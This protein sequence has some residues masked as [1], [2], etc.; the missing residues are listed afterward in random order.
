MRRTGVVALVGGLLLA[1]PAAGADDPKEGLKLL[2]KKT[3]TD[4]AGK[5]LLYRLLKPENYDAKE[6]YPLVVF[7]HGAGER[8]NDNE[9]QLKHGVKEF[10][11]AD[12]RKKYPCFLIAP[13]CPTRQVWAGL[14]GGFNSHKQAAKPAEPGRLALELI[15]TM[16]KEY[17][18]DPK[19]I[20]L[21]GLSMGGYGTWDLLARQ[22]KLFAAAAPVC[23]GGDESTA[24][25]IAQLP[26]WVF[27]G[28]KDNAVPVA[29]SRTMVEALKKAGGHPK[30]TE[31]PGVG[32]NSWD[33]AYAD[34]ELMK[35]LF[36]QKRG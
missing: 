29:R 1:L 17:S 12:V 19:R 26:I 3:Y 4:P 9:A 24:E 2:E 34:P 23:G 18:I 35:W 36:A 15:G 7:L 28:D 33:K 8:G 16:Q 6:K 11:K 14:E 21:T 13:Q 20:Y 31:Y 27:H 22:P 32:H 10:V 30:Y 25:K 5:T